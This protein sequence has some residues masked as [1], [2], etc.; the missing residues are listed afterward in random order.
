MLYIAQFPIVVVAKACKF[1]RGTMLASS[2][3]TQQ[4]ALA[5]AHKL[6]KQGGK[7]NIYQAQQWLNAWKKE[8]QAFKLANSWQSLN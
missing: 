8:R 5:M 1:K 7:V 4:T 3:K 6:I 2:L